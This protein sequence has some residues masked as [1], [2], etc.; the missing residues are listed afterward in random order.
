MEREQA[1]K[2]VE[3][4]KKQTDTVKQEIF[5]QAK[6]KEALMKKQEEEKAK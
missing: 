5:N 1:K 4:A 3:E 6:E 2:S